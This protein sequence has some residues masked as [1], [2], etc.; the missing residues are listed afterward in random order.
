MPAELGLL[1]FGGVTV[2]GGGGFA[3]LAEMRSVSADAFVVR[4]AS[5][6]STQWN[7]PRGRMVGASRWSCLVPLSS[8]DATWPGGRFR[9][10]G[11]GR[12]RALEGDVS[13]VVQQRG[14][15]TGDRSTSGIGETT[16]APGGGGCASRGH[17]RRRRRP[18]D[19]STLR[20]GRLRRSP[21]PRPRPSF[22]G[23]GGT[24]RRTRR[25]CLRGPRAGRRRR[26]VPAAIRNWAQQPPSWL[27]LH[28]TGLPT[29]RVWSWARYSLTR[30]PRSLTVR[31]SEPGRN[32]SP[33]GSGVRNDVSPHGTTIPS[34]IR[35][36]VSGTRSSSAANVA[37]T[38]V[39]S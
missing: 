25:A 13:Q 1:G 32:R 9:C 6:R 24:R 28:W 30:S 2:F 16:S 15:T 7:P 27:V 23:S 22:R 33:R 31:V 37:W 20:A 36:D 34:T 39:G 3:D 21:G 35:S 29:A 12:F 4:A 11:R 17:G 38:M 8:G 10:R 19:R 26:A 5:G 18:S 14:R